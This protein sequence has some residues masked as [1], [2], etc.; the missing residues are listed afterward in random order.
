MSS[1][2]D[3]TELVPAAEAQAVEPNHKQADPKQ[4][5]AEHVGALLGEAY[6]GASM[7]KLKPGEAKALME[8]FP[9]D[10]VEIRT[11][12]GIIYISHMAL[13]ERLWKVFGP[14]EVAEVCR[15]RLMRA[16][17][18]EVMVDLVLMVRGKFVAEGIGTAKWMPQNPKTSFGDVVESAWSEA[19]RR[20]CKKIGVGTQVW[21][22]AYIREWLAKNAE[23][24]SGKWH[25]KD[26]PRP[27]AIEQ[28]KSATKE[29]ALKDPRKTA[30]KEEETDDIPF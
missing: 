15:E 28:R 24:F 26:D 16:D 9:D 20:C 30:T 19:L 21:R 10:E 12:D 7:L 11:F 8:E 13:R 14:T 23:N 29:Y 17:T 3:Q 1:V 18:N 25:R 2:L 5:R 4:L 6:K 27:A 22:P